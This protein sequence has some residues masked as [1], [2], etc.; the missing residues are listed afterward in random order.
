MNIRILTYLVAIETYGSVSE[1]AKRLYVS[2][3]YLSKILH[4]IEEEYHVTIFTRGKNG[5]QPT[6]KGRLFLDMAKELIQDSE[7][8]GKIFKD[9]AGS[10]SLRIAAFPSSYII[11]AYLRMIKSMPEESFRFHYKEESTIDVIQDI[12]S[13]AADVG[14]IFLKE[15][16]NRLTEEFF[17]SRRII[18]RPIFNANLHVIVRSGHPLIYKERLTLDDLYEYNIVMYYTKKGTGI[19]SL[20]DGYYNKFSLPE[21]IDFERFRQIIYIYGRA[22]MHNILNQTDYIALG[23]QATLDQSENFGLV[24]LPFPFPDHVT[25]HSEY[26]N[27]LYYI[28]L[29]DRPLSPL[30]KCFVD[31]LLKC[32]SSKEV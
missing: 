24:S 2:Q 16:N 32:Y 31:F 17:K 12:Y 9:G 10:S 29:Q 1:A 25:N 28:Y 19:Y 6:E 15:Q 26:S 7:R 4:D 22:S 27:T 3:P 13:R 14:V 11:D 8:F 18:C 21:L 30:A 23:S 20:E 5:M